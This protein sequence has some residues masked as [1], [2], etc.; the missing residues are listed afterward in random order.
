MTNLAA[1]DTSVGSTPICAGERSSRRPYAC[2][3]A[4]FAGEQ[5][6]EGFDA[7]R[8]QAGVALDG[9]VF[10]PSGQLRI[11]VDQDPGYEPDS[12]RNAR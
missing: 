1:G 8:L 9:E 3:S 12:C 7:E 10:E 5:A 4:S 6:L 11:D 2:P